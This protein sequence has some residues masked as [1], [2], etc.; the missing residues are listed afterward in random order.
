[1]PG[2][3]GAIACRRLGWVVCMALFLF[4]S[5]AYSLTPDDLLNALQLDPPWVEKLNGRINTLQV[6]AKK[7][8]DKEDARLY[9]SQLRDLKRD[10]SEVRR[11]YAKKVNVC[12]ALLNRIKKDPARMYEITDD[13]KRTLIMLVAALGN[14]YVTELLLADNPPMNTPDAAGKVALD[15]EKESGGSAISKY[16]ADRWDKAMQTLSLEEITVLIES[17]ADPNW[18]TGAEPGM[19]PLSTAIVNKRDDIAALLL[20]Y[21]A[22]TCISTPTVTSPLEVAINAGAVVSFRLMLV[23]GADMQTEMSDRET[24]LEHLLRPGREELLV[25]WCST[26]SGESSG[27]APLCIVVRRGSL[28]AV[29]ACAKECNQMLNASDAMGNMPLHEAARR[30]EVEIYRALLSAG[31]ELGGT[32]S[33]GE[34]VLMHAALSGSREMLAAVLADIPQPLLKARDEKGRNALY[35]ARLVKDEDAVQALNAAGLR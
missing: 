34:T 31:A 32:N 26:A 23:Y 13:K 30:G 20:T 8:K 4:C 33:R 11:E 2:S 21:K 18:I 14:D 7:E 1:M 27:A 15:Y 16:L 22:K 35:Y 17:G 12:K 19:Y 29:Q 5:L 3:P 25:A 10:L 24:A 9:N 28:Q 6:N